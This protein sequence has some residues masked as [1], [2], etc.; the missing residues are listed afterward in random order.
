MLMMIAKVV[1]DLPMAIRTD[2]EKLK[3]L[4][5]TEWFRLPYPCQFRFNC[6]TYQQSFH[7]PLSVSFELHCLSTIIPHQFSP[8]INHSFIQ[9]LKL[10]EHL[11]WLITNEIDLRHS[12][13]IW[14]ILIYLSSWSSNTSHV[15]PVQWGLPTVSAE[16]V[17]GMMAGVLVSQ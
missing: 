12:W 5:N 3:L 9:T 16:G 11:K 7:H 4:E 13:R 17:L 2:G 6:T 14:G 1:E 8:V 15:P 10:L